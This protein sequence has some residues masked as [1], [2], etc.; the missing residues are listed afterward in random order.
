[1][2]FAL[3]HFF[4][5]CTTAYDLIRH[6]GVPLAKRDFMGPVHGQIEG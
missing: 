2:H 6:S 5:H 3:P 1:M 4:F